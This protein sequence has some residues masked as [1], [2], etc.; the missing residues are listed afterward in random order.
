MWSVLSLCRDQVCPPSL[1]QYLAA[2]K[3]LWA[4]TLTQQQRDIYNNIITPKYIAR[5][6]KAPDLTFEAL[7]PWWQQQQQAQSRRRPKGAGG[8]LPS[9][10]GHPP[11]ST[12]ESL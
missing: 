5:R 10:D 2:L 7:P 3:R 6:L 12:P 1:S 11:A 8:A 4:E 9:V